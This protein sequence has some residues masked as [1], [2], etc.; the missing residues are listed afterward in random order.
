MASPDDE[1]VNIYDG[2]D[3]DDL[4]TECVRKGI[5]YREAKSNVELVSLLL[6][7]DRKEPNWAVNV[8]LLLYQTSIS[9][10]EIPFLTLPQ[11]SAILGEAELQTSYRRGYSLGSGDQKDD[12]EQRK[13][14]NEEKLA[15][16]KDIVKAFQ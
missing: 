9:V 1:D 11:I 13:A 4:V 14:T 16:V 7:G 5:D 3:Y 12:E 6:R 10:S 2:W 15:N 8:A